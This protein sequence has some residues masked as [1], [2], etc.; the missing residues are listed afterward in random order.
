ML[1]IR[2]SRTGKKHA[3]QYRIVVQEKH[4]DPWSPA[5]DVVGIYN[6][7]T[8]P[9][10]IELKEDKI[11]DW[12]AKGAQPSASVQNML[13]NAGIIKADKAKSVAISNKR[14]AKMNEKKAEE[15]EAK[16]AKD[17]EAK[18]AKEA[19]EQA[20]KEAAEAEAKVEEAPAEEAAT[21]T[22]ETKVEEVAEEKPV[23]ALVEKVAEE[24]E[25]KPAE[26]KAE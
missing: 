15:V 4:T 8:S 9:S 6:P 12:L 24:K 11:K 20:V 7:H 19:E 25:E 5:K 23:D 10:T 18:A 2:L 3:P 16:A 22:Q 17:A 13:I 1:T 26:E 21:T 14:A